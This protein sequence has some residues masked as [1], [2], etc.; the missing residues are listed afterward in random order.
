MNQNRIT[1]VS[2]SYTLR[3]LDTYLLGQIACPDSNVQHEQLISPLQRRNEG[4]HIVLQQF[5]KIDKKVAERFQYARA[6]N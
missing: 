5:L 3:K 2:M 6:F 1:I 4:R